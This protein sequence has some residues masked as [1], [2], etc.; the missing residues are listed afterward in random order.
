MAESEFP[1]PG[2]DAPLLLNAYQQ[3]KSADDTRREADYIEAMLGV[4]V[5]ARLLD[6]P[7]G[8]GRIAL[9]L[10]RRGYR[11]T[12][13]DIEPL[14]LDEACQAAEARQLGTAFTPLESD[15][16]HLPDLADFD[17]AYCFWESFGHFD[18]A[19]NRDFLRQV[20]AALKTGGRFLLD[21]HI[22][23]SMLPVVGGRYFSELDSGLIV[24][25]RRTYD[26][27]SAT[28]TRHFVLVQDGRV[29]RHTIPYRLYTYR[30][31]VE[32]LLDAGFS[33]ATG[34]NLLTTQPFALGSGRV[35]MVAIR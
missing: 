28:L 22:A 15:M 1:P 31:L 10:A 11:V 18:E 6:V 4:S 25:E 14:L 23:E 5:P 33:K 12:G 19:D 32:R 21:T 7:C 13:V 27:P 26:P 2:E 9:E 30:E 17:G 20:A 34:Y 35:A 3:G 8:A 16:R 24:M 29:E